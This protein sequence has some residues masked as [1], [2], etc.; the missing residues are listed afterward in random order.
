MAARNGLAFLS[1]IIAQ[2]RCVVERRAK[3]LGLPD[4]QV[5]WARISASA[6][7][8]DALP[9]DGIE[10]AAGGFPAFGSNGYRFAPYRTVI[11]GD[12]NHAELH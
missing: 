1:T 9:N 12:R 10:F 8:N 5:V 7:M 2:G 4:L 3:E 6:G 11:S